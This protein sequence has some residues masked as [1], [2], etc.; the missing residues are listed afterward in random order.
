M[1]RCQVIF[2]K[3]VR[4]TSLIFKNEMQIIPNCF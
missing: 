1:V 3:A 2:E 4:N